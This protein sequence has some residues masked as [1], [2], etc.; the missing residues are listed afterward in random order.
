MER[1]QS[2][3]FSE[4]TMGQLMSDQTTKNLNLTIQELDAKLQQLNEEN[5]Q[6]RKSLEK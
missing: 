2:E 6:L 4:A 1:A 5:R 3:K